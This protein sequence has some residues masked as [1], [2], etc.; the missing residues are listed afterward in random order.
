[1]TTMQGLV[2]EMIKLEKLQAKTAEGIKAVEEQYKQSRQQIL[3]KSKELA[4]K[5][6]S[7]EQELVEI[8]SSLDAENV[9]LD[10]EDDLYQETKK[11]MEVDMSKLAHDKQVL[12]KKIEAER[13]RVEEKFVDK[14]ISM[15]TAPIQRE[16]TFNDDKDIVKKEKENIENIGTS[17]KPVLEA[18]KFGVVYDA[19]MIGHDT[20]FVEDKKQVFEI[21]ERIRWVYNELDQKRFFERPTVVR[22]K[23]RAATNDELESCHDRAYIKGLK[24][25]IQSNVPFETI[26]NGKTERDTDLVFNDKSLDAIYLAAGCSAALADTFLQGKIGGGIAIVRPPGH[27]AHHD[28]AAGFCFFNNAAI[29][30]VKLTAAGKKVLIVDYDV[31]IGDGTI[32]ILK[33]TQKNN[34]LLRYFSVH[35]YDRG[36]FYP[37]SDVAQST[38]ADVDERITLVGTNKCIEDKKSANNFNLQFQ[39]RFDK[40]I[41]KWTPDV[42]VVSAGFDAASKD[43]VG[44]CIL[45]AKDYANMTKTMFEFCPNILMVLE[46]GYNRE[47]LRDCSYAAINTL[48]N[49]LQNREQ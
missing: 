18:N 49:L 29:C 36:G 1:M 23:S 43:P 20:S 32:D 3:A 17:P 7:L 16:V 9:R 8:I 41:Y 38:A 2:T 39:H 30:A 33:T 48:E 46:G 13:K 24:E 26:V 14:K 47:Q 44:G 12:L 19:K 31:H 15:L 6:T 28:H 34:D 45:Y 42:I 27:H 37:F 5:M 22:I 11:A 40:T 4:A 35:R 10:S 21:P 25:K